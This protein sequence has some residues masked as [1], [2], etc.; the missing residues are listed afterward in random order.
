MPRTKFLESDAVTFTE[1]VPPYVHRGDGRTVAAAYPARKR[2]PE[3]CLVE[4]PGDFP[5]VQDAL[6]YVAVDKLRLEERYT[7]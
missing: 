2:K 4:I 1:D 3:A 7:T 5:S 6:I